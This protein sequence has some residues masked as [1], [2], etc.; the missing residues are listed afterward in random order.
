MDDALNLIRAMKSVM[1]HEMATICRGRLE[2][3][4]GKMAWE[5]NKSHRPL[6]QKHLRNRLCRRGIL[7]NDNADINALATGG[8]VTMNGNRVITGM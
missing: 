2:A 1:W 5:N 8:V 3:W 7:R 4:G 6:I